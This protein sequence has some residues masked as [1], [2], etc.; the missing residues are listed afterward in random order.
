MAIVRSALERVSRRLFG[1]S[2][3][4]SVI[5]RIGREILQAPPLPSL[6]LVP[7][8]GA[9]GQL[10]RAFT[11]PAPRPHGI[12]NL[13]GQQHFPDILK[14]TKNMKCSEQMR[15]LSLQRKAEGGNFVEMARPVLKR[16][17]A[18]LSEPVDPRHEYMLVTF[19]GATSVV[20]TVITYH[21]MGS[22]HNSIASGDSSNSEDR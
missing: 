4:P 1:S 16:L 3:A 20:S 15:F 13:Q 11:S 9:A 10:M 21:T 7:R 18:W 12:T 6:R 8:P 2:G 14:G 17:K 5:S 22:Y 19:V